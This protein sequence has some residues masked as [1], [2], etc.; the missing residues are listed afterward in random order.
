[1]LRALRIDDVGPARRLE[2][3]LGERLNVLTGDNGL[4]KSFVLDVAFWAMTGSWV[5]RPVLP[6]RG[7]ED[8]ALIQGET[9]EQREDGSSVRA[10]FESRFDRVAQSWEDRFRRG[11]SLTIHSNPGTRVETPGWLLGLVPLLYIRSDGLFSVWD[12]ARILISPDPHQWKLRRLDPPI[13]HF[14]PAE[15]WNGLKRDDR[16]VCNGLIQDWVTWQLEA[17]GG[18][19]Q[20]FSLLRDVLRQLSHP[21]EPMRPGKPVRLYLDDVRRFPTIELPYETIP[22]VHASAGMK[23]ILG[24]AYLITWMWTEHTQAAQMIGQTPAGRVAILID[25]PETHLH[26]KWQR[27]IVPALLDVASSLGPGVR[28][29]VLMTTH[30]PLVLASLETR[31]DRSKDRLFSFDLR[32]GEVVLEEL[33]W[34][35]QGDAGAWL[36]SEVFDLSRAYSA[37]AERA[38]NAAYDFMAGKLD[39]LP[40]ELG[41]VEA[42]QTALERALPDQDPLWPEWRFH[43][44]GAA[45]T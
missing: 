36:T 8:S 15:L 16:T 17:E 6:R 22:V 21:D 14:T 13:Y 45:P 42:I 25:E 28:P 35:K 27:H 31:F 1:M 40:P 33:P 23:R 30:S 10:P 4:G 11:H 19:P 29:Q 24:L 39:R 12:P 3:A 44:R 26:P 2:L 41:T 5:E 34:V 38:I 7:C 37:E 18:Q 32:D 20:P 43:R 9:E